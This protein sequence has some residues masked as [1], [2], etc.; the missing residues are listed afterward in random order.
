MSEPQPDGTE[1]TA[2]DA[3]AP[4]ASSPMDGLTARVPEAKITAESPEGQVKDG[5]LEKD[6]SQGALS[7]RENS[8][9]G[10]TLEHVV[11]T[12]DSPMLEN[13]AKDRKLK[14]E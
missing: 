14:I 12:E 13:T 1:S 3:S 9:E 2:L 7:G 5:T 8:C 11:E 10:L 4:D 6:E